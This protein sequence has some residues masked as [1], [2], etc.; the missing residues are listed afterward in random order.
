MACHYVDSTKHQIKP[1]EYKQSF[2]LKRNALVSNVPVRSHSGIL[3]VAE[4]SQVGQFV[5]KYRGT[6][7]NNQDPQNTGRLK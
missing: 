7:V 4:G 1:G 5:G 2:T 6:V 3:T